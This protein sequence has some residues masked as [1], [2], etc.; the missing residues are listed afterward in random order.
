MIASALI[1]DHYL[2]QI[3]ESTAG[4]RIWFSDE[5]A[6]DLSFAL[7]TFGIFLNLW[8][9]Q[10]LG[11]KGMFNGDSFGYVRSKPVT[12]GPYALFDDP[13]YFGTSLVLLGYAVKHQSRIGYGLSG[14]MYLTFGVSTWLLE[15]P[16]MRRIYAAKQKKQPTDPKKKEKKNQ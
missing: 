16:H 1:R 11:W 7:I 12:S 5:I 2:M 4:T 15:G 3:V 8:V 14:V 6:S 10:V 13:Q 9:L